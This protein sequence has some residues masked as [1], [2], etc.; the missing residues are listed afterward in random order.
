MR[1]GFKKPRLEVDAYFL[2][3]VL[4]RLDSVLVVRVFTLILTILKRL[5]DGLGAY[6]WSALCG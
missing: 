1:F 5:I 4:A 3:V 6:I 2:N